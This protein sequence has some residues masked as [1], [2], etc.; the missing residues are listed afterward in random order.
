MAYAIDV[1][2]IGRSTQV[3]NELIQEMEEQTNDVG[4]K[5]NVEKLNT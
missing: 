3:I 5:I 2:I 1:V 4:L